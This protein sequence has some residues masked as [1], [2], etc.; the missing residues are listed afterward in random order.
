[1]TMSRPPPARGAT[2]SAHRDAEDH[3]SRWSNTRDGVVATLT[4]ADA[5][6]IFRTDMGPTLSE[7]VQSDHT[8]PVVVGGAVGGARRGSSWRSFRSRALA[9]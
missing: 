3:A 7:P 4:A 5:P 2:A 6:R 8:D 9:S 1:M